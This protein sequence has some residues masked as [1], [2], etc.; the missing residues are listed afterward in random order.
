MAIGRPEK[1]FK[2]SRG[3]VMPGPYKCSDG[4]W[5]INATGQKFSEPDERRCIRV[6]TLWPETIAALRSLPPRLWAI[7]VHVLS[8]HAI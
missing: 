4:R 1:P 2:T 3:E 8:R 6:A 7:Y 5:R